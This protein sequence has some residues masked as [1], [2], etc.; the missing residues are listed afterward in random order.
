VSR[1]AGNSFYIMK[2][3]FYMIDFGAE[4]A[5]AGIPTGESGL[6]ANQLFLSVRGPT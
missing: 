6:E 2:I 1:K 3:N 5:K 4:M